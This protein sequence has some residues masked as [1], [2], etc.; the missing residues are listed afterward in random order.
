MFGRP[1]K[2]GV[3]LS[4]LEMTEMWFNYAPVSIYIYVYIYISVKKSEDDQCELD[5]HTGPLSWEFI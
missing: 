1:T 5:M 3:Q 2:I 4:S